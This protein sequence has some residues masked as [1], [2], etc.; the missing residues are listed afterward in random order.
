MAVLAAVALRRAQGP[1]WLAANQ[2]PAYS[3]LYDS[4][5]VAQGLPPNHVQHPGTAIQL[6]GAVTLR[7][8]TLGRGAVL[9]RRVLADPETA[10]RSIHAVLLAACALGMAALGASVLAGTGKPVLAWLAQ[11]GVLIVP[12]LLGELAGVKPE[13]FLLALALAMAAVIASPDG[14]VRASDGA[15][16]PRD[17]VGPG[18]GREVHGLA[19]GRRGPGRASGRRSAAAVRGGRGALLLDRCAARAAAALRVD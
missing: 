13:P 19:A 2:D 5:R 4:L 18:P 1:F 3:Y 14:R 8:T 16:G 9:Q 15:V 17:R 7:A 12:G 6:L 10:L 11:A